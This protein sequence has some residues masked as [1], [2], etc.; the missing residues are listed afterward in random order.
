R[1]EHAKDAASRH[2]PRADVANVLTGDRAWAH[3]AD[4]LLSGW[5][6]PRQALAKIRDH[7]REHERGEQAPTHHHRGDPRPNAVADAQERGGRFERDHP[8][9]VSL[10]ARDRLVPL[11]G[12]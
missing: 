3:L 7:R 12:P 10:D 1:I 2:G 8:F 11:T 6:D 9:G 4:S 5:Q